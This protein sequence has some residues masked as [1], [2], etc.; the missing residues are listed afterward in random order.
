MKNKVIKK[1]RQTLTVEHCA[2]VMRACRQAQSL[3]KKSV[4]EGFVSFQTFEHFEQGRLV[5]ADKLLAIIEGY[6]YA[7]PP[8]VFHEMLLRMFTPADR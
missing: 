1:N 3:G 2:Q 7:L 8:E 6:Y 4:Y 5:Y